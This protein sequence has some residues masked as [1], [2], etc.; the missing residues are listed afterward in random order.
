M[1]DTSETLWIKATQ[2]HH[3]TTPV[4]RC[5]KHLTNAQEHSTY[6]IHLFPWFCST[7]QLTRVAND[8]TLHAPDQAAICF[9][10]LEH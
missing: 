9:R 4:H 5:K 8:E 6:I 7:D 1:I 3:A 2:T 10:V